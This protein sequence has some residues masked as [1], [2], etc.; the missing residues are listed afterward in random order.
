ML[1]GIL[2]VRLL[3]TTVPLLLLRLALLLVGYCLVVDIVEE[4]QMPQERH[5]LPDNSGCVTFALVGVHA[6]LR[7]SHIDT[8]RQNPEHKAFSDLSDRC[9]FELLEVRQVGLHLGVE[10]YWAVKG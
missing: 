2:R 7:L 6:H 5:K 10:G 3:V 4:D 1:L 8:P 9:V